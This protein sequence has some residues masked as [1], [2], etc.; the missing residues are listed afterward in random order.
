MKKKSNLI[1]SNDF[2]NSIIRK[3][4][5]LTLKILFLMVFSGKIERGNYLSKISI[6]IRE[7][8]NQLKIDFKNLRQNIKQIQK[9]II[10]INNNKN[11]I[12]INILP[13]VEYN[14]EKQLIIVDIYNVVLN[15]LYDI[16][17]KYTSINLDNLFKLQNKHSIRFI[18]LLEHISNYSK[19]IAKV[20][21]F[22]INELNE[23]FDTN[24]KGF[25]EIERAIIKPIQNELN[26][27]S[28]ITFIYDVIFDLDSPGVG[29]KAITGMKIYIKENKQ[30][31]LKMF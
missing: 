18:T 8:K 26:E 27:L 4:N 9:T 28:N 7:L 30:R 16:K 20:K 29:R 19:F 31:Q 17:N 14:Y 10:T 15:E 3:N 6:D 21:T 1:V 13:L 25:R 12:D 22:T 5:H 2:I 11:I 24:Y 23:F